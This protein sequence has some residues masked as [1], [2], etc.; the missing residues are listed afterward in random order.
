MTLDQA[1]NQLSQRD[2]YFKLIN[3]GYECK[4][5]EYCKGTGRIFDIRI[6]VYYEA[7]NS[8]NIQ[9]KNCGGQ[10]SVW[11]APIIR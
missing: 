9:C 10:G 11:V 4:R 3:A 1:Y 6:A 7:P 8:G 5:C 2:K